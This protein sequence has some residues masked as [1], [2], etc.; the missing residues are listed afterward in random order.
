M[1]RRIQ[2][3]F[4]FLVMTGCQ[5]DG[6]AG[7]AICEQAATRYTT[8]VGELLGPEAKAMAERKRD[9]DACSSDDMTVD[10]YRT[11]LPREGCKAFMDCLMDAAGA[12]E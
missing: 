6:G 10:M 2:P 7:R 4:A 1:S 11:C 9:I 12:V 8:C 5:R 3:L